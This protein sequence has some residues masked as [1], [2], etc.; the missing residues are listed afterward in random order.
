VNKSV[1]IKLLWKIWY[2]KVPLSLSLPNIWEVEV[3]RMRDC[4]VISDS[5]IWERICNPI[6]SPPLRDLVRGKRRVCIAIDDLNRPTETYRL[7]P[8]IIKELYEGGIKEKDIFFVVSLG[9]HRPLTRQDLI[10]KV[11]EDIVKRFKIYNHSCYE[12]LSYVGKTSFGTP[13]Y[14]NKFFMEADFKLGIGMLS[15]HPYAG[16]SGGGKIVLPGLAGIETITINHSPVKDALPAR[17]GQLEG[18]TR[19]TEI[20]EA[21]KEAGLDF[22]INTVSNSRG[23]TAGVFAGELKATFTKAAEFA[24]LVYATPLKYKRDI[25]IFNSFPKDTEFLQALNA[26]NVWSTRDEERALVRKGGTI[27]IIT[28]ASEGC[29][30]HGLGDRGMRGYVRRDKHG[31][32]KELLDGRKLI[33]FSPNLNWRDVED[34]YPES[35]ALFNEWGDLIKELER[36]YGVG[37]KVTIYPCAPLQLEGSYEENLCGGNE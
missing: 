37:A 36:S 31:S 1:N 6:Q 22:L 23:E 4:R 27:V 29:G 5:E 9:T 33:F 13:L 19:R 18:N 34:H 14:I 11:G 8:P 16:F 3:L 15:P 28:A 25:G 2:G 21:A 20:D 24:K 10:K 17:V 35:V 32:F 26:L 30:Y 7:L 12:N